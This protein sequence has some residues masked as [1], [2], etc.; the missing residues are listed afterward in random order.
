MAVPNIF[1]TKTGSIPLSELDANFATPIT[2]GTTSIALGDTAASISNVSLVNPTLGTPASGTLTNCTIP[3][4]SSYATTSSLAAS[5]GSTLVG[6]I[7]SGTGATAR[8]V[9]SKLND[10]VS[11]KDFGAVGD[12]TTDDTLAI[13]AAIN[14]AATQI[15]VSTD[16][17]QVTASVFLPAGTY[18]IASGNTL[19]M[20]PGVI[21][22]GTGRSATIIQ[23]GGG[24]V[25]CI[26]TDSTSTAQTNISIMDLSIIGAGAT[27]TYGININNDYRN[28][29]IRQ[30]TISDCNVNFQSTDCWTL[31]FERC[32]FQAAITNNVNCFNATATTFLGCRIDSAGDHNLQVTRSTLNPSVNCTVIS[33]YIQ[34]AQKAGIYAVDQDS[35]NVTDC[36]F[37]GNN[38]SSNSWGDI[39]WTR[40]ASNRGKNLKVEGCYGSSTTGG[41]NNR[42]IYANTGH[43]SVLGCRNYNSGGY[44]VGVDLGPLVESCVVVGGDLSATTRIVRASTNTALYDQPGFETYL[45]P[46]AST[47]LT[48]AYNNLYWKLNS[49]ADRR[50]EVVFQTGGVDTWF[51]GRGD[52]D[53]PNPNNFYIARTSGGSTAPDFQIEDTTGVA[54]FGQNTIWGGAWNT[55]HP[56]L[57]VNHLWVDTSGRLRI[58]SSAPTS[59]TDGTVVGTQV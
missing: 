13:Q 53:E 40:G 58:K 45:E 22:R 29:D 50:L 35:L 15:V 47:V 55:S 48:Q 33:S 26:D 3:Q 32:D 42:F 2:V 16:Y 5:T 27:T 44:A 14:Y 41:T 18:K 20:K 6:T 38:K 34:R 10:I 7:Q 37:E 43:V 59:A 52:S 21:L 36:Y 23:H 4:L 19:R 24:S 25:A 30:V 49:R 1:A 39:Y 8:T 11:V 51:F 54:T 17:P 46:T 56:I 31:Y 57:G 28:G 9:G 12:G